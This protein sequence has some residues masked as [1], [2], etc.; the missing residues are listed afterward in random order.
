MKGDGAVPVSMS[1]DKQACCYE[2][3]GRCAGAQFSAMLYDSY[4]LDVA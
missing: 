4:A 3:H 1:S 2:V